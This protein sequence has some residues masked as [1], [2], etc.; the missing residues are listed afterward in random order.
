M[1]NLN[2]TKS[3]LQLK[4]RTIHTVK[5]DG[6]II[7]QIFLIFNTKLYNFFWHNRYMYIGNNGDYTFA[8]LIV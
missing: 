6:Q 3:K 1:S 4:K 2:E 5:C 8:W 7:L